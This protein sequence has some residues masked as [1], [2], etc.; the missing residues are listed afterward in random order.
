MIL[1][2]P[3]KRNFSS[4]KLKKEWKQSSRGLESRIRKGLEIAFKYKNKH[5][6]TN[7]RITALKYFLHYKNDD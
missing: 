1:E 3:A 7:K 5:I 6:L 4:K 2:L